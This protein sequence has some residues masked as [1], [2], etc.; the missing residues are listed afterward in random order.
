MALSELVRK[1]YVVWFNMMD[2]NKDL[3]LTLEDFEFAQASWNG[4][5]EHEPDSPMYAKIAGYW[6]NMWEG[7]KLGDADQDG[8][9]GVE[10]FLVFM[11]MSRQ[12]EGYLDM[13]LAWGQTTID[14]FDANHDGVISL[15]EWKH[16]YEINGLSAELAERTFTILDGDG[17]GV[18]SPEEYLKRI[19]EFLM[20]ED[21]DAPGNHFYGVIE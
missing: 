14:S 15:D 8:K 20:G 13:V 12:T 1:K 5:F 18:L 16:I 21:M 2:R 11:D 6:I 17:D 19:E 10:E 3:F 4:L 7:L 9:V